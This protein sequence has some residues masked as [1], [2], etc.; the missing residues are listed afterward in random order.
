ME[1]CNGAA[2]THLLSVGG[3]SVWGD[4]KIN[5]NNILIAA[6]FNAKWSLAN[7][8]LMINRAAIIYY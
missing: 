3:S 4:F 7:W 1:A 6:N 8:N 5:W 2:L